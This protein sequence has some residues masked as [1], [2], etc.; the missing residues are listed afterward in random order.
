LRENDLVT[1]VVP[2]LDLLGY[3]TFLEFPILGKV[4]DV[5]AYSTDVTRTVAI[6]CKVREWR[7]GLRQV[8]VY[9][10]AVDAVFLAVPTQAVTDKLTQAVGMMGAGLITVDVAGRVVVALSPTGDGHSW[11]QLRRRT[12]ER[13]LDRGKH[14]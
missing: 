4:A 1:A 12:L 8:R 14:A 2:W 7:R 3:N 11:P 5:Y 6:E 10:A 9:Q 13:A